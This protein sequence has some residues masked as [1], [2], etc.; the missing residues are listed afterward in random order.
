M[1]DLD[2]HSQYQGHGDYRYSIGHY[3]LLVVCN[4]NVSISHC[5]RELPCLR[6]RER[7]V[8]QFR[9]QL[10]L[11]FLIRVNIAYRS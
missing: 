10:K 4:N 7:E 2:D 6:V 11:R 5:F 9:W 8:L 3:F 1:N